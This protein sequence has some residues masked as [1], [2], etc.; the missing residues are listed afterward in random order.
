MPGRIEI[1]LADAQ[2]DDRSPGGLERQ[3]PVEDGEGALLL[4]AHGAGV[5]REAC[6]VA[7]H[8]ASWFLSCPAPA[9]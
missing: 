6:H 7:S 4:D 1:R 9:H 3:R 2:V 8:I 5:E